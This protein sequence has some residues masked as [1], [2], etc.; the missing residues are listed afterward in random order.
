[1]N[2]NSKKIRIL[3]DYAAV[4]AMY[5]GIGRYVCEIINELHEKIEVKTS[6]LVTD[7]LYLRKLPFLKVKSLIT[8]K[9]FKGKGKAQEFLNKLYANYKIVKN[10]YDIFH[11]TYP[12]AL[13]LRKVKKPTIVTIHDMIKEKLPE[14]YSRYAKHIESKKDLIYNSSHIIA[15]SETTRQDIL[16]MY[17]IYPNKISVIYHGHPPIMGTKQ[18][19]K[20]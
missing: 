5:G 18:E 16:N 7:N 3:Y 4:R 1:M 11:R 12:D 15:V 13:P 17:P 8:E 6:I 20:F 2:T 19:N 10:D 14:N 9:N